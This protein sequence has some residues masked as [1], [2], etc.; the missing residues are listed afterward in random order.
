MQTYWP[1]LQPLL[2]SISIFLFFLLVRQFFIRP[3]LRM[4]RTITD[5]TAFTFDS[6]LL[7]AIEQPLK[8][9]VFLL[10]VYFALISHP[11]IPSDHVFLRHCL[12]TAIILLFFQVLY[13]LG[14]ATGG[15][16]QR[17]TKNL[18]D[19]LRPLISQVLHFVFIALGFTMVATEWG[20]DINGFVAGLGLGSLAIALAAKDT[21]ANIFGGAVILMDKPFRVGDW[22]QINQAEGIVEEITFRS[23]K[24]RT[25]TQAII[26]MPNALLAN[27]AIT[28]WSRM[29]KRRVR[30]TLGLTYAATQEQIDLCVRRIRERLEEEPD[31]ETSSIVVGFDAYGAN[32]LDLLVQYFTLST[33][34][35]AH[36]DTK[37]RINLALL[38]ILADAGVS[39]A[40][41]SSSVYFETPLQVQTTDAAKK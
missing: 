4:L 18:D 16:T 31:V 21:V 40:Y 12:R 2:I 5:K 29:G 3:L 13:N 32:S 9:F 17:I 10:G 7:N 6:Q 15:L 23:T 25:F 35:D 20:Y 39:A 36:F 41:P 27:E 19:T 37:H 1:L 24:I 11:A 8:L 14:N 38:G 30:F 34:F 22:V 26:S 33:A 28:N